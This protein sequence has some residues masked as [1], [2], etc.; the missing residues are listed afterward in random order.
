MKIKNYAFIACICGLIS[1]ILHF[2]QY[3]LFFDGKYFID[4]GICSAIA[5]FL[6]FIPFIIGITNFGGKNNKIY[7][8]AATLIKRKIIINACASLASAFCAYSMW[9]DYEHEQ[10]YTADATTSVMGSVE[11]P[12]IIMTAV[13]CVYLLYMTI[14]YAVNSKKRIFKVLN[15][16]NATLEL[17]PVI[18]GLFL[19]LYSFI[20]HTMSILVVENIFII[21]MSAFLL[22][23]LFSKAKLFSN[24]DDE[25][26][27][28]KKMLLF[29]GTSTAL[30]IAYCGSGILMI[31]FN[32][33]TS[34]MLP[35]GVQIICLILSLGC[36]DFFLNSK[37]YPVVQKHDIKNT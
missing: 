6:C 29:F 7:K 18:W 4:Y 35:I 9:Q 26:N 20:H 19:I 25:N 21:V 28:F 33:E 37:Y 15:N 27:A 16:L 23:S 5:L 17:I 1:A 2:L 31:I 24:I 22:L 34:T 11:F 36:L 8:F 13:L 14:I 30:S 3:K 12:F 10:T 32:I